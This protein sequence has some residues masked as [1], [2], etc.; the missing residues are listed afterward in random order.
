MPAPGR[1]AGHRLERVA[2]QLGKPA[3]ALGDVARFRLQ[4]NDTFADRF[5]NDA[6][7]L[8]EMFA[9]VPAVQRGNQ[10]I[11]VHAKC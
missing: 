7:L 6:L 4:E 2:E 1:H 10:R 9:L 5:E 8:Q 3:V 11:V